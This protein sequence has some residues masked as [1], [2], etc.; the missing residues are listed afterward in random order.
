MLNIEGTGIKHLPL[1]IFSLKVGFLSHL[2]LHPRSILWDAWPFAT[3]SRE[4]HSPGTSSTFRRLTERKDDAI[5]I[6]KETRTTEVSSTIRGTF[7]VFYQALRV[8]QREQDYNGVVEY[9]SKSCSMFIYRRLLFCALKKNFGEGQKKGLG[10]YAFGCSYNEVG[11]GLSCSISCRSQ[12]FWRLLLSNS[13]CYD[14]RTEFRS[15]TP[16]INE[17]VTSC[18]P[19]VTV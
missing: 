16:N 12:S 17:F 13:S 19:L 15:R 11:T 7:S 18:L 3:Y 5:S 6:L 14:T 10:R 9:Y 8:Q 2:V 1:G 4:Y